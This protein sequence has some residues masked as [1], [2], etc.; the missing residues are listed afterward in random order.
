M[1]PQRNYGSIPSLTSDHG[2]YTV[3]IILFL[4]LVFSTQSWI[5]RHDDNVTLRILWRFGADWETLGTSS[6]HITH[7][8]QNSNCYID[9]LHMGIHRYRG[10]EETYKRAKFTP[11]KTNLT[12]WNTSLTS[13][14]C[15]TYMPHIIK[16]LCFSGRMCKPNQR[17]GQHDIFPAPFGFQFLFRWPNPLVQIPIHACIVQPTDVICES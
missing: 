6:K 13:C 1:P 17:S 16:N 8:V 4:Y 14:P 9:A 7:T 15:M 5:R 2:P 12:P 11:S 10:R 3:V